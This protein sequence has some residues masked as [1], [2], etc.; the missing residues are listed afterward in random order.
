MDKTVVFVKTAQCCY[1]SV[2][3][4][5]A[6][7]SFVLGLLSGVSVIT[8]LVMILVTYSVLSRVS[9]IT[10][11]VMILVTYSVA[12]YQYMGPHLKDLTYLCHP[13]TKTSTH[14]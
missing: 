8:L 12:H 1:I 13:E 11:L 14:H 2:Y 7:V 3:A 4:V 9:V 6:S 10:L 5:D